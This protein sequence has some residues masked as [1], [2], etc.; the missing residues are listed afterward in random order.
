MQRQKNSI[1]IYMH[2]AHHAIAGRIFFMKFILTICFAFI[3]HSSIC[4]EV[5]LRQY[6]F[7]CESTTMVDDK[8]LQERI[9]SM[10]GT[11]SS[12]WR[13]DAIIFDVCNVRLYPIVKMQGDTLVVDTYWVEKQELKLSNG[14]E[15]VEYPQPEECTCAY[16]L[17]ME[18]QADQISSV[19]I[20]KRNLKLTNEKF[21]TYPIKYLIYKG[22]TTGYIDKYGLRQG[23]YAIER[24]DDI[25][26][27]YYKDNIC[28][29][30]EL[31]DKKGQII[32]KSNE[33]LECST[34]GKKK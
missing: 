15:I 27:T 20:N 29:G 16:E 31:W 3:Y 23:C 32:R 18:L 6:S 8:Y 14:D 7:F 12:G 11:S 22:D 25:H 26:K 10:Q 34:N 33:C 2:R 28:L 17:R 13:I 4:Q 30:C 21:Q 19:K 1:E 9:K 5:V 24:K